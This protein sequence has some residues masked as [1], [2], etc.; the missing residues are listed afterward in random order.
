MY[1]KNTSKLLSV[2]AIFILTLLINIAYSS[3]SGEP[4]S[5]DIYK[6]VKTK[7][8]QENQEMKQVSGDDSYAKVLHEVKK[9]GCSAAQDPSGYN[10]DIE[11]DLESTLPLF[12]HRRSKKVVQFLF[13]NGSEGWQLIND[14]HILSGVNYFVR[15]GDNYDGRLSG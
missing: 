11:I 9:V 3:V 1:F 7:V 15:F 2:A 12:G 8:D 10:C 5:S 14:G 6:A 4:S 13:V